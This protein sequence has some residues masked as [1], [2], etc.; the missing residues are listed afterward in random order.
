MTIQLNKITFVDGIYNSYWINKI[1]NMFV[2][3]GKKKLMNKHFYKCLLTIKFT[4]NINPLIYIFEIIDSIKP[5]FR[6]ENSFP[7]K[8]AIVYPKIINAFKQYNIVIRW[9]QIFILENKY[10]A[11]RNTVKFYKYIVNSL[12]QLQI[13]K[14]NPLIKKRDRYHK[15]AVVL[16]DN[17]RYTWPK[18]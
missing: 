13:L 14:F 3:K 16:Q 1:N 2:K 18:L 10:N 4:N 7:S 6:L 11:G 17:M 8:T 15:E 9:I 5:T 12:T